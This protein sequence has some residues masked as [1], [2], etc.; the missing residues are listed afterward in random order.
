MSCRL[1]TK[2][3]QVWFSYRLFTIYKPV[4]KTVRQNNKN[5]ITRLN[6]TNSISL[7]VCLIVFD[8]ISGLVP[9]HALDVADFVPK[10][11][12]VEL[13]RMLEQLWS[14]SGGNKLG[15][16]GQLVDH[17]GHGLAM[18]RVQRLIDFVEQIERGRIA[19]L[20]REDQSERDQGLL[21]SGQ[22]VHFAHFG[23]G[24]GERDLD[25]YAGEVV[26]V[27]VLRPHFA[28]LFVVDGLHQQLRPSGRHEFLEHFGEVF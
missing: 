25:A 2:R 13:V 22:L 17:V 3:S 1:T 28:A 5:H 16:G 7:A 18:L 4:Q 21:S 11:D 6:L 8:E 26:R 20:D 9:G 14:E 24:V 10:L 19:L 27:R 12:S 23:V 15:L